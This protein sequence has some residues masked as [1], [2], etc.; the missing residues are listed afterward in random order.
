MKFVY[1]IFFIA[2]LTAFNCAIASTS[3]EQNR[4]EMVHINAR[5][6]EYIAAQKENAPSEP[7]N[8]EEVTFYKEAILSRFVLKVDITKAR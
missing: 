4:I 5:N 1:S 7:W 2:F 3:G 6:V 8:G